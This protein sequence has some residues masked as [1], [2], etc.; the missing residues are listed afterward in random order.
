MMS[1]LVLPIVGRTRDIL[2]P[3]YGSAEELNRKNTHAHSVV[4]ALDLE[5]EQLLAVELK[6]IDSSAEFAGEE[7]GGSRNT[8]RFW[9]CDPIDGTSHL[10]RGLPFC[11]VMLA[12]IEEGQVTFSV[13]YDFVNNIFY[14]AEKGRGAF[15]NEKPIRVSARPIASA[16]L[17]REIRLD[18][19]ENAEITSKLRK[20]AGLFE[21]LAA[22]Y[23]FAL[24]A[25]G[26]LEGRVTFDPWGY[27]FDYAAGA[28]LVHE[29]GGRVSNIGKETYDYRNVN[30][31]AA[32][33]SVFESLT[34][35]PDALFPIL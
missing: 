33:P 24:V 4:T 29:A 9:L 6:K 27:D 2:M 7:Q 30:S 20:K 10:I 13:I 35:D 28:F 22:G 1:D 23:E 11:T 17:A 3:H 12:L 15:A 25:S 16:Y 32:N 34:R 14:H 26:R 5:I 8:A 18:K 21:V 31:L 19:E